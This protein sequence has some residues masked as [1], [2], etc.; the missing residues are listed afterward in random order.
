MHL[1]IFNVFYVK[2]CRR[3]TM[4]FTQKNNQAANAHIMPEAACFHLL[5]T[6]VQTLDF[7]KYEHHQ[8]NAVVTVSFCMSDLGWKPLGWKP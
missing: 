7:A 5:I 3:L 6:L 1:D 8:W 4:G 2:F